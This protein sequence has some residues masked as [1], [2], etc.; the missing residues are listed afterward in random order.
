MRMPA[1]MPELLRRPAAGAVA[2]GILLALSFPWHPSHPVSWIA[3]GGWAWVALAPLLL[4][5]RRADRGRTAFRLGWTAGF[6]FH[7]ATLYW[8]GNTQGGGPAVVAGAALGAAY[9]SLFTGLFALAQHHLRRGLGD[10]TLFAAP[11]TWTAMEYLLSL[12]ELG[13]PWLLLAHSQGDLPALLQPAAF[14]GA[15]GVSFLVALTGSLIALA[16]HRRQLIWLA[17]AA[18][19]PACTALAGWAVMQE[20]PAGGVRVAVVQNAVGLEKWRPGGLVQSLT[21]LQRLSQQVRAQEPDL[22]V[23]PEMAV[24]CNLGWRPDCRQLVRSVVDSLATPVL[25]G[26]PDT[27]ATTQEPYNAAFL[28]QPHDR[29]IPSY[30]K[31]HLVPFGE[32]TPWRDSIPLLR[33]IDWTALTGDLGPAEF[34]RGTRRT[35]FPVT[36]ASGDSSRFALLICF[37]SIFPDLVRRSVAAGA[38]FLVVITNDS[39]FGATSGPLQHAR[40]AAVRAVEN[41]TAIARCATNG[42]SLFIDRFGRTR[43]RTDHGPAAVRV[44]DVVPR[45]STTFYTRHGDW[46]AV[47]CLLLT[48]LLLGGTLRHRG[49]TA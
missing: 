12:G 32:R 9:V 10:R 6:V 5:L 31:M 48:L 21:G 42:V 8:I 23:W 7:L 40:L 26:A 2:S 49:T 45:R 1:D 11:V 20:E 24:P 28:F 43:L 27:D 35:L 13:F 29:D 34:A 37:E 36:S 44:G 47:G 38:D 4:A 19:V 46:F 30:A 33:D 3:G 14:F 41:R 17:A 18:A 15:W 16:V 25:T 22:Y 39:W